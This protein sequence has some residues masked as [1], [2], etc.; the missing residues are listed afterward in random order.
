MRAVMIVLGVVL[1]AAFLAF[2]LLQ[3]DG[4]I[5]RPGQAA[6]WF[7][8]SAAAGMLM[9]GIIL[10]GFS[11]RLLQNVK[12]LGAAA[13][14][15][16]I[17]SIFAAIMI[18]GFADD[19]HSY[20]LTVTVSDAINGDAKETLSLFDYLYFSIITWTT[21][22]YGDLVPTKASRIFAA[23]EALFGY[24]YMAVY[25]GYMLN[26][27]MFFGERGREERSPAG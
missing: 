25:I 2:V 12:S 16:Y 13:F 14:G 20:G 7:E 26:V 8:V 3:Y 1:P 21:V 23:T 4:L 22:G 5:V 15:I 27:L 6:P 19:Y 18:I 9:V 24:I 11:I 10:V 17:I